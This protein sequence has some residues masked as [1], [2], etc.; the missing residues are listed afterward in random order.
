MKGRN[1]KVHKMSQDQRTHKL[2]ARHRL[3]THHVP[4]LSI[5]TLTLV[6]VGGGGAV[7]KFDSSSERARTFSMSPF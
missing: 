2:L 7:V 1:R 5:G 6:E 4:R 3:H